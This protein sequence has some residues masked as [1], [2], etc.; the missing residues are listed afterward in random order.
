MEED[1]S[2]EMRLLQRRARGTKRIRLAA[3]TTSTPAGADESPAD[4]TSAYLAR[5]K[6]TFSS[7]ADE[8]VLFDFKNAVALYRK[9]CSLQPN[10]SAADRLFD[11]LTDI[12]R[13]P[14]HRCLIPGNA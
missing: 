13:M 6:S 12:F 11:S 7:E 14:E 3:T 5:V 4:S 2:L 1:D 9:T 10:A 8:G